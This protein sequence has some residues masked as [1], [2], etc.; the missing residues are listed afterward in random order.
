MRSSASSDLEGTGLLS[1]AGQHSE[2]TASKKKKKSR[3]KRAQTMGDLQTLDEESSAPQVNPSLEADPHSPTSV[4]SYIPSDLS[5]GEANSSGTAAS[6]DVDIRF[7]SGS[8]ER[9]LGHSDQRAVQR[10]ARA[11][12][13]VPGESSSSSQTQMSRPLTRGPDLP[14]LPSLDTAQ[15]Q[16]PPRRLT[17][18]LPSPGLMSPP[19][20]IGSPVMATP[21][22]A[23]PGSSGT[24][25]TQWEGQ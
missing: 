20:P 16:S 4:Q 23:S 15:S 18:A 22:G 11:T 7:L 2:S 1:N 13:T 5:T 12:V 9:I 17:Q 21:G 10:T 14:A 19:H 3:R 24:I 25:L 6:R 8:L